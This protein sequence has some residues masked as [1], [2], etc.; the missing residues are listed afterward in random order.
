MEENQENNFSSFKD[1]VAK[2]K[3]KF[4]ELEG[5]N[6]HKEIDPG[7]SQMVQTTSSGKKSGNIL[8]FV[9]TFIVTVAI[10]AFILINFFG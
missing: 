5:S 7:T 3:Q 6:A 8:L 10:T 1:K 2:E 4:W 9:I